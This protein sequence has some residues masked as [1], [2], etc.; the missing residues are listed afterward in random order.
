MLNAAWFQHALHMT[1]AAYV[2]TGFG[3]AGLCA[4]GMLR[5]HRDEYHRKGLAIAIALGAI[6]IP[7]QILSGDISTHWVAEHQP[8]KFAALEGQFETESGAGLSIGSIF[9]IPSLLLLFSVF[10]G[11]NP[12]ADVP[13]SPEQPAAS[14]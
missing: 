6:V 13:K 5:G 4:I 7:L 2:A 12:A 11:L 9:L 14:S 10:K 3:V 8:V 1:L